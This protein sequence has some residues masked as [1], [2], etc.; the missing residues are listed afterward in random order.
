MPEKRS[1]SSRAVLACVLL[2]CL[3][4]AAAAQQQQATP[5]TTT[6]T[7][8]PA[9]PGDETTETKSFERL[10]WRNIGPA[11]MGG[12]IAD[13]EGVAGNPNLVYVAT[14]S[15]GLFKTT[16]GGVK[17]T[18][19][20]ERQGSMS[21]GDIAL[22]PGNPDVIWLGA[23]ESA[24]RNSVS[25]GDG[26]YKSTDGGQTWRHMGL[27]DSEHVSKILI[28]SRNPD[29]VYV[30]AVGH[31]FGPNEERGVFMTTDGG[32]TWQKTL[33]IDADHGVADMDI[34]PSNPNIL[35]AVMWKFRRTPWTHTSGDERGGLFKSVD[36]GRSWKKLEGGL[37]KVLGRVGVAVAASSPNVVYAITE[38]KE[39][40]LWRSDDR[41]E[42]WRNVS[43]QT[44][45]VSR[46]FYYTHVRV[47]P[48][49]E[50][51]VFAVA[52]TL[53]LSVDG[54]RSFRLISGRTHVDFHALWLDSQNPKR[55]WQGQDGG[56]AVTYDGGEN[57]EVVNNFPWGQFYQIYADNR[58]PFYYVMGG[59]QDNGTWTGPSRTREPSGIQ[60]DDWRMISFGDGFWVLNHPDDPDL[61]LSE[62]QGGEIVR[63][64]M[65]T[66]EQQRVVPYMGDNGGPASEAK[67]R[68]NW[69]SPIVPSPHDKN[70]VYLTGNVVFKSTDFG[71]SWAIIS[72]DLTTNDRAKQQSA[73]GPVAF[74]NTGA[75]YHTTI[76]SFAESPLRA[77]TLWAGTDDGNLQLT[78][79]GGK[80][81]RNV[82]KNVPGLA[83]FSPVSHVE[84][85]RVE[86][87]LTYVAFDR[88][89]L[90]DRRPYVF[91]TADGGRSFQNITGNLPADAY[92]HIVREDPKNP[93]LLYAG[94]ERGLYVS[95][96]G[97]GNWT[98]LA[99]KNLP[100]VAVHDIIVHPR[101]NDLIIATHG[102]SIYVL[103]DATP[104][105]QLTPEVARE[106]AH[107]FDVRPAL[108][109]AARMSRYGIGDKVFNG[110][111]PPYGALVSYYLKAK[112]DDKTKVKIQILDAGGKVV[113]E[114]E[115][116]AKER[117][118][119]RV[120]WNLRFGGP[121]V[122][123]PSTDEET[124]FTGGPRGPQVLPGT[125]TV[126]L[127]VGDKSFER[128]VEVRLDPTVSVPAAD[129]Q[130]TLDMELRLRDMQTT[131]N[132]ALRTLDSL[133]SQLDFV[134]RTVRDR[135]GAADVPKELADSLSAQKK[136]V[137]ELS[138]KLAQP[139][140]GL[141]V[142]GRAQ[143]V[144]RIGGLFFTLDSTD[145]APTPA[146]REFYGVLQ[147]EFDARIAEVNKFLSETVPQLNDALRRAG[148]PTLM[149][150][151]LVEL[152]KP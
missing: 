70:T 133:K 127:L 122:R 13:I 65:K 134:E 40:T 21:I 8:T 25:F 91:K 26:V 61:Y 58:E 37:P 41:G 125:Y 85:S 24:V 63:T 33:Y 109:Y 48:Q 110:A 52:S 138:N 16:N 120:N 128:K 78:N 64:D 4:F 53:F 57:W 49:N 81:W 62:S 126:R 47:D 73:G 10:E 86:P 117:G 77:G 141:G 137:E 101:D 14:A 31:A 152:P 147:R 19:L 35:Y 151:K 143:L 102:R 89:M 146:E 11:N 149:T 44:S 30:G 96:T 130:A 54:G 124:Q 18:P 94:T 87:D 83:P 111:N 136:R 72:P 115:N 32:R 103:D 71:K 6:P 7:P 20:F 99:L 17:W 9:N 50:N 119:N 42:T 114:I 150:G 148:A 74:E 34:D 97:G 69:N 56:I 60:N 106:D 84:P 23:G 116:A 93:H 29:I 36:G 132:S 1:L 66:R 144:D 145:A 108:R 100:S 51:R 59:L 98:S 90:D 105:Q 129:L 3:A 76:I 140:G 28:N 88:H 95:Y 45:I 135:L 5:Q 107:L 2:S 79:D 39:G 131:T 118:L 121:Q 104:I 55:M 92:V 82:V 12:R 46:G 22:E 112:P 142:E 139:E 80:G 27:R 75:E 68:F 15:G 43:K 123:R 67:Y 38:A 113:S